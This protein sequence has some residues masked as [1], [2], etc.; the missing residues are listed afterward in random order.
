MEC[1]QS[2]SGKPQESA[3][4]E[5]AR[6]PKPRK[7][8]QPLSLKTKIIGVASLLLIASLIGIY[9]WGTNAASADTAVS[10]FFEALQNEDA[11]ALAKKASLSNGE[12]MTVKQAEVFIAEYQGL[13]PAQ[14]DGVASIEQNGKVMGIFNAHRVIIPVQELAFY[15]PHEGLSLSL[16]GD[17]AEGTQDSTG[18]YVFSGITPGAHQAEFAYKGEFVEFTHPFDLSVPLS[19]EY[20]QPIAIRE[21]L[22]VS[23]V[24]FTLNTFLADAPDA[25]KVMI[26]EQ[27]IPVNDTQQTDEIGPLLLDGSTSAYAQV[28]FPWGTETSEPV[29]ITTN[30]HSI[31]FVG[32][33]EEHQQALTDQVM[34]FAEEYVEAY[35]KR[36]AAIF[37]SVS[38]EQLERFQQDID[39]MDTMGDYFMGALT[40]VG[41]DKE[42]IAIKRDGKAVTLNAEFSIDGVYYYQTEK[43]SAEEFKK[44]VSLEFVYD[45][46]EE[47]WMV[48][49]YNEDVWMLDVVPTDTFEG[50]G[51]VHQSDSSAAEEE[52]E[53][54]EE[55]KEEETEEATEEEVAAA[56]T[57]GAVT[58]EQLEQFI[59][60]FRAAYET[61]LNEKDFL[62][63]D[64]FLKADSIARQEL[65]DFIADTGS[66]DYLY[67]FLVDEVVGVEILEDKA[68]VETNEEFDF[69]NHLDEVTNY[70]RNKKYEVHG[71]ESGDLKIAGI[72]I[73]DTTRE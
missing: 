12:A 63:I 1:G 39:W 6:A 69:T 40:Q 61:A 2:F 42:S 15:F 11:E 51:T 14:L 36:D 29:N 35:A 9:S 16:N 56:E 41:V 65:V 26:G 49:T 64:A 46:A 70:K 17:A 20:S 37:T 7:E 10:T 13:T 68:F 73:M 27:E 47:K 55:S 43:P 4:S 66:E 45:Q 67:E 30:Y 62:R 60:D 25:H 19:P 3:P 44:E 22:P 8:K 28:D 52:T 54:E 5:A 72:D 32:M 71:V 59:A 31:D 21:N 57:E 38:S 53:K 24:I 23:S 33:D 18:D 48:S 34:V 58:E 50:S